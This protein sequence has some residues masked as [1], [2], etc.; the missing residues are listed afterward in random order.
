MNVN[1]VNRQAYLKKYR[2]KNKEKLNKKSKEHYEQ[3]KEKYANY[4]E[5]NRE[6]RRLQAIEYRKNNKEKIKERRDKN[7]ERMAR[8]HKEYF[9]DNKEH[10][11]TWMKEYRKNNKE[12]IA[13]KKRQWQ[14]SKYG[15]TVEEYEK[16][17]KDQENKCKICGIHMNNAKGKGKCLTID[18]D[19]KTGKVRGLLCG[20]C[21]SGLG[22][23]NE[24]IEIIQNALN[25]LKSFTQTKGENLCE[26]N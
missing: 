12:K 2:E 16:L 15:I 22:L 21:N 17:F 14:I 26:E 9:N 18:H 7:K 3:N 19:H 1:K 10:L 20:K 4:R 24:D 8:V 5:E 25:Y 13:M 23:F 11:H 6:Y